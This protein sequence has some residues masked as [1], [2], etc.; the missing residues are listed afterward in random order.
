MIDLK[1]FV[2]KVAVGCIFLSSMLLMACTTPVAEEP[3]M[4]GR[5][6]FWHEWQGAEAQ[7]LNDLIAEFTTLHPGVEVIVVPVSPGTI[8][9]RYQ[10]RSGSGL[11]PDILLLDAGSV[12]ELAEAGLLNDISGQVSL[13]RKPYL[14]SVLKT[15][16]NGNA[17]YGIPFSMHTQVLFYNKTM[18]Q[19]PPTSLAELQNRVASGEKIALDAN[20]VDA[21]W[22]LGAFGGS[23]FDA[24]EQLTLSQGGLTNWLDFLQQ[25]QALPGFILDTDTQRLRE[26][27]VSGETAYYVGPSSDLP[28]LQAALSETAAL[29]EPVEE[30]TTVEDV[31]VQPAI[32]V[33]G[34]SDVLGV[35]LLHVGP[36][37]WQPSPI[38]QT[39]AFVFSRVSNHQEQALALTLAEFL[40]NSQQQTRLAAEG[41]GRAPASG[42]VKRYINLPES[43]AALARQTRTAVA[44]P[45]SLRSV[46]DEFVR[47]GGDFETGYTRALQGILTTNQFIDD[48]VAHVESQKDFKDSEPALFCHSQADGEPVTLTLWHALPPAEAAA[49]EEI[50]AN[51]EALCSSVRLAITAKTPDEIIGDYVQE[52]QAG[53]GPDILLESSRWTSRLAEQGLILDLSDY[54]QTE[55][56]EKLIPEAA[57]SMRY[58]RRLYGIPQSVSVLALLYNK[59]M[60]DTPPTSLEELLIQVSP[61]YRWALPMRFFY[62]YWGLKPFGGFSFNSED[63]LIE[64]S[65]GLVPWLSWLQEMQVRPGFDL[66]FDPQVAVDAFARGEAAFLVAGPWVLPQLR[67]DLGGER[68]GVASLPGGP[69][70]PG[71]PILQVEGVMVNA[72]SDSLIEETVAFSRYLSLPE[73]QAILLGTGTHISASVVANMDDLP[74]LRGFQEE[75]KLATVVDENSNFAA[76]EALGDVMYEDVLLDGVDPQTAVQAFETAVANHSENHP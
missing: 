62:G 31:G 68:I 29:A 63:G 13:E 14:P 71:S 21:L 11:G 47:T 10:N 39:D 32:Y 2:K 57:S 64:E 48:S 19:S 6:L 66:T 17:L 49:L 59:D 34:A 22:G 9:N 50:A 5:I 74:L 53:G 69:D 26:L 1:E 25:A 60:I 43:T 12:F 76:M 7:V 24:N 52:T 61:E 67:E 8:E 15:V 75:A 54:V 45:Y 41:I 4:N 73:S 18:V 3:P 23:L 30:S 33:A 40:T 70:G 56:L 44:I 46:W 36:N 27:F 16:Q 35:S 38:L 65:A 28:A 58:Q 42:E 37:E 20:L 55:D 72:N 51:Y